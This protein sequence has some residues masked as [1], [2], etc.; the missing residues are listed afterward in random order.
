MIIMVILDYQL[1]S[2]I[3]TFGNVRIGGF[4]ELFSNTWNDLETF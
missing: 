4:Y 1:F 3:L 2:G